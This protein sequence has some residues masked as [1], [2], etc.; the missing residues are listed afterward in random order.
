MKRWNG[1]GDEKRE[2]P[3]KGDAL[4]FLQG[5]L[6]QSTPLPD[7]HLES[8]LK[9]VPQSRVVRH[10]LLS[11][12]PEI[13]V[14]HS[15]GQSAGDWLAVKSGKFDVFP[16]AVAEPISYAEVRAV[17]KLASD[18]DYVL[19][20]YGG[21]TSVA[22]HITPD[23]SV[24]PIITL[25]LRRLNLLENLNKESQI[26]TFGAGANGPEVESQL[27]G[28]GYT[29]GH[30]PQSFELSTIGGWVAT[31]SSG[32]QSLR[33][34]RIEQLYAG[35][36]VETPKGTLDVPTFP[37]SSAGPDIREM[38]LGSE[39]RLG[40]ITEVKVRV[41]R[42]PEKEVFYAIFFPTWE[43]GLACVREIIQQSIPLSMLRLSNS[44]E[45]TTNLVLAGHKKNDSG[46]GVLFAVPWC[47][48][49]KV[50]AYAWHHRF[51]KT[52]G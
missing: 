31:R 17:I 45:T 15:R 28:H 46:F 41:T 22:G 44:V 51:G 48:G 37:A 33:Y 12:D 38:V 24:K 13:R 2:F 43:K 10:P 25:S 1:W 35:G 20:P 26:A 6:G 27:R 42:L 36:T 4:T 14:R 5:L 8:V 9:L 7:A 3:L 47:E 52:S 19:I 30:F 34:G 49:R 32:Q 16:D 11:T 29:L 40:V 50:H 39:G 23:R 18:L 21:G